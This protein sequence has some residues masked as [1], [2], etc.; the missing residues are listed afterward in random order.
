MQKIQLQ[1]DPLTVAEIDEIKNAALRRLSAPDPLDRDKRGMYAD[2]AILRL[3]GM[4]ESQTPPLM[5]PE[6][7]IPPEVYGAALRPLHMNTRQEPEHASPRATPAGLEGTFGHVLETLKICKTAR[8]WREGWNG[9]AQWICLQIP[10]PYSK[11]TEPYLFMVLDAPGQE[12]KRIP[13]LAS[14]ADMLAED[15]R[16]EVL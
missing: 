7:E 11:M 16:I 1:L 8:A 2:D 15:W 3:C 6:Q 14:Q 12:F 4:A 9:K 10:D 5:H 13:W